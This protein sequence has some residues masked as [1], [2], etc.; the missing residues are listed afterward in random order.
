MTTTEISL[1]PNYENTELWMNLEK[2]MMEG[3]QKSTAKSCRQAN[4][5][6]LERDF[7]VTAAAIATEQQD[8]WKTIEEVARYELQILAKRKE[9]KNAPIMEA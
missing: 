6:L 8:F 9:A 3:H 4:K 1:M 5:L 2:Q 7:F